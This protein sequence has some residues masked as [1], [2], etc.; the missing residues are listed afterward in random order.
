MDVQER[1]RWWVRR[2]GRFTTLVAA[3]PGFGGALVSRL[4][5]AKTLGAAGQG[6]GDRDLD[7]G[8][9]GQGA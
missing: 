7:R 1:T 3:V 4:P 9:Q 6:A 2:V 5:V 8:V